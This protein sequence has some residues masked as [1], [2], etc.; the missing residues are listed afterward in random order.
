MWTRK[1]RKE[2][3]GIGKKKEK[4]KKKWGKGI[5]GI[6][7][8]YPCDTARRSCFTKRFSK[9]DSASPA[10]PLQQHKHS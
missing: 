9:T 1:R 3:E 4:E 5:I 10:N 8:S 7:P 6:S 2:R